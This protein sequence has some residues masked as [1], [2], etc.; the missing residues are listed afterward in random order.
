M[1]QYVLGITGT[2]SVR[3]GRNLYGDDLPVVDWE[4]V[5]ERKRVPDDVQELT[6]AIS[7]VVRVDRD[8]SA[9]QARK[10]RATHRY[11]EQFD[12]VL[13]EWEYVRKQKTEESRAGVGVRWQF[14]QFIGSAAD[15]DRWPLLTV[16]ERLDDGTLKLITTHRRQK[17]WGEKWP[18]LD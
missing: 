17:N 6:S 11:Y 7:P 15:E 9:K 5:E 2:R 16:L 1:K 3:D 12:E 14:V 10:H 4:V 8:T 13:A 18:I